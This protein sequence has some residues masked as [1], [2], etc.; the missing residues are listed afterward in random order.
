MGVRLF[1]NPATE[2]LTSVWAVAYR[3]AGTPLPVSPM[4]KNSQ[5]RLQST[6]LNLTI[7]K[8]INAVAAIVT[9]RAATCTAEKEIRAFLIRIKELPQTILNKIRVSHGQILEWSNLLEFN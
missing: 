4:S 1:N 8:G 7:K 2:L 3:K 6:S 5:N 9:R